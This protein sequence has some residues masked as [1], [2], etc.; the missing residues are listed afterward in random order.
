M[1]VCVCQQNQ[2]KMQVEMLNDMTYIDFCYFSKFIHTN[3]LI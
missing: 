3:S 2:R 1:Y